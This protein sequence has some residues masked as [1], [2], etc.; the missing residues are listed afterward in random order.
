M[1]KN[2]ILY[3][4]YS[5]SMKKVIIAKFMY[6]GHVYVWDEALCVYYD[7]TAGNRSYI[8]KCPIS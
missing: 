6:E 2:E 5:E 3:K 4:M 7:I 1:I 8:M